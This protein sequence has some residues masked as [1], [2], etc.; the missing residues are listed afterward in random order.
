MNKQSLRKTASLYLINE[1]KGSPREKQYRRFVIHRMIDDLF[2]LS[3]APLNWSNLT[4]EN[5]QQLVEY[6]HKKKVKSSTIM[7]YMTIIRKFLKY[8][9]HN[10]INLD[11]SSLGLQSKKKKQKTSKDIS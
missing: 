8:A 6:W 7:N 1:N 10:A 3:K 11:N 9:G 2:I 5:L 4:S